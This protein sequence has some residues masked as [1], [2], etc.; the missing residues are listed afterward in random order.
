MFEL[1]KSEYIRY[2][3]WAVLIALILLAAFGF[4]S[5]M[6]PLLEASNAQ[7]AIVNLAFLSGSF[8]FGV[9]QMALYKRTNH[10]TY[11]IHRPISPSK[12]YL[13]LCG[14]G[15]TLISIAL[16]LP[17]LLSMLSLDIFTP[18]VVESR[19]YLHVVFLL[20]T[21]FVAYLVGSLVVLNASYGAITLIMMLALAITPIAKNNF[22]QFF[23]VVVMV[24]GLI[25]LNIKSFKPDLSRH[26]TAPLSIILMAIPMS[27]A[28]LFLLTMGI[29]LTFYHVPKFIAGTHPD[30]N[31]VENTHRY[32]WSY[33][34]ADIPEYILAQTD[35][36][37]AEY[38]IQQT[39]LANV[40]WIDGDM[41]TFPR[42]GQLYVDDYQYS[43]QHKKTGSVWQFSHSDML[44][45]GT[46]K[47]TGQPLGI[48]GMNG[49][50]NSLSDVEPQ[51]RFVEVPFLM[52]ENQLMT[53]KVIYQVNFNEKTLGKKFTPPE[54]EYFINL[55]RAHDN[56]VSV[57]T[58]KN[59]FLFDPRAYSDEYQSA[60][61]DYALA[62]PVST[63]TRSQIRTF[64]LADGYV[65]A[66]FGSKHFGFDRP[67]AQVF[68]VKLDGTVEYVGGREFTKFTHPN[69][70]RHALYMFSPILWSAQNMMFNY[71]EPDQRTML[72][73]SEIRELNFPKDVNV[74]AIILHIISVFGALVMSRRHRLRPAQVA[75][76]VS[77]CAFFSLPALAACILLNP[78]KVEAK[79]V[80]PAGLTAPNA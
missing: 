13:G 19:H 6:K 7:S 55:P 30:N 64:Q 46:N 56:Y 68:Y 77:L 44:L 10:W 47:L 53:R 50:K 76:W 8:L 18:T 80:K 24:I 78:F 27:F 17:W 33:D 66:Y 12:I 21:C 31:P 79:S 5:K 40:G 70:I 58:N 25:Y 61:P 52:G 38:I 75:T 16:G 71:I 62:H 48:L 69:W 15:L 4:I 60:E 72:S 22:V 65:F 49:F 11:L 41:W 29:T 36:P 67:G 59:I 23:P 42:Q 34:S 45:I 57:A 3:K 35:S 43:F 37:L 39:K 14:A 28:G 63:K 2:Q 1:G 74:V 20:L 32:T 73:L 54:G 26:L 51:D 9:L